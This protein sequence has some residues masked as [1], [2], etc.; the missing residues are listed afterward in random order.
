MKILLEGFGDRFI[1][2]EEIISESEDRTII[3]H[4][5]EHKEKRLKNVIRA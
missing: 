1:H 3:I 4:Y 5:K 2:A